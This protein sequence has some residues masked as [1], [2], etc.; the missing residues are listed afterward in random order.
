MESLKPTFTQALKGGLISGVVAAPLNLTW[1]LIA[2]SLGSVP[3]PNFM[4]AVTVS[5]ILPLLIGAVLYFLLV[6]YSK[7]GKMIFLAVSAIFTLVSLY[8]PMQ[9]MMPD[10]TAAPQGFALLTIPMHLIAGAVAMW[11]IPKFSN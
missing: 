5:S 8:G 10:G 11:G 9:P 7:N 3:P 2:P 6:K 4:I 1:N